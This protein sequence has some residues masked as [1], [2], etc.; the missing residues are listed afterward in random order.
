MPAG[1]SEERIA[2]ALSGQAPVMTGGGRHTRG[3]EG[4][5]VGVRLRGDAVAG[6]PSGALQI[7]GVGRGVRLVAQI[8][9]YY[10]GEAV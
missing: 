7:G 6:S 9:A 4:V 10:R 8:V 5:G 2:R 1:V 3:R